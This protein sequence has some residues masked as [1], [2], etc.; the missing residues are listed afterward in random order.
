MH[1]IVCAK[2]EGSSEILPM[3]RLPGTSV[4]AYVISIILRGSP[5]MLT[6]ASICRV[7]PVS[8]DSRSILKLLLK[9]HK[10]FNFEWKILP[11]PASL[12]QHSAAN[13]LQFFYIS[14]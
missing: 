4:C 2:G 14:D 10:S 9:P 13:E 7:V 3:R 12:E 6:Q 5:I 11:P 8:C 1:Y